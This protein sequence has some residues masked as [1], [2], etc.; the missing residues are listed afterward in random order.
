MYLITCDYG[1]RKR[2][3]TKREALEWL[4]CCG[5]HGIVVNVWGTIV[6]S[7][8]IEERNGG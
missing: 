6:A 3:W 5:P 7:R 8:K 4:A 1:T 2:A